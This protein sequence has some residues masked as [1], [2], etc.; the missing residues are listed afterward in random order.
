MRAGVF[1]RDGRAV[2]LAIEDNVFAKKGFRPQRAPYVMAPGGHV[3]GVEDEGRRVS[4][5]RFV[6]F[7]RAIP[8]DGILSVS[9]VAWGRS[10]IHLTGAM[11]FWLGSYF[12]IQQNGQINAELK[13][14]LV[15]TAVHPDVAKSLRRQANLGDQQSVLSK[16]L[17][18]LGLELD[19]K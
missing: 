16:A 11:D 13:D 9:S 8:Q 4:C 7:G 10:T 18:E 3:P 1:E 5:G 15:L 14:P 6:G 2:F 19:V 12:G 17:E